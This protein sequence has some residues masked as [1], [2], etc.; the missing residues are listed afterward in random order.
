MAEKAE[1]TEIEDGTEDEVLDS[2][3]DEAGDEPSVEPDPVE[4]DGED[5]DKAPSAKERRDR[6]ER[7]FHD[8]T[9][10]LKSYEQREAAYLARL[11]AIEG[12]ARF[13][14]V[15]ER[16][17]KAKQALQAANRKIAEA[18]DSGDGQ[19]LAAANEEFYRARRDLDS[20]E[21]FKRQA[22]E[23]QRQQPPQQPQP[24][25]SSA[26]QA[27]LDWA[28]QNEGWFRKDAAKTATAYSINDQLL[29]EGRDPNHPAFYEELS[30]RLNAPPR[31]RSSQVAPATRT[32]S[33]GSV[34]LTAEEKEMCDRMS[35]DY[36]SYAKE[37]VRLQK[38]RGAR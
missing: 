15:S 13:Q 21:A 3:D 31:P 35:I 7:R 38:E 24:Q 27:A 4:D 10:K 1:S 9:Q 30:R 20:I 37:K 11:N 23:R 32:P 33:K 8:L 22:A 2:T 18:A 5:P 34:A 36:A 6:Y 14:E 25:Q 16:E 12:R 19:A 26:P 28:K 17:T 29:E